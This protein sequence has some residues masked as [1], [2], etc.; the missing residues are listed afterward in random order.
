MAENGEGVVDAGSTAGQSLSDFVGS[1]ADDF[2]DMF[3][4]PQSD[5]SSEPTGDTPAA[6]TDGQSANPSADDPSSED[7]DSDDVADDDADA[8]DASDKEG[9]EGVA[10]EAPDPLANATALGYVVDGQSRNYD[11][12]RVIPGQGAIIKAADLPQ[13]QQRLSERDHLFETSRE[14]Y[15]TLNELEQRTAWKVRQPDGTEKTLTG[16]AGLVERDVVTGKALVALEELTDALR[17]P[18]KFAKLIGVDAQ[19]NIVPD[20]EQLEYLLTRSQLRETQVEQQI[21]ARFQSQASIQHTSAQDSEAATGQINVPDTFVDQY[22]AQLGVTG[23]APEDK[24]V[25]QAIAPRFIRVATQADVLQNPMLK[26][27]TPVIENAFADQVKHYASLRSTAAKTQATSAEATKAALSAQQENQARLAAAKTK[28][29]QK[30]KA[31]PRDEQG[32]FKSDERSDKLWEMMN[33]VGF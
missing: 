11:A 16:T 18:R 17:D 12:I 4:V 22:A 8:T 27:G 1:P 32:K 21:R 14:Q 2:D 13:L 33:G 15:R 5:T 7:E 6:P 19:G 30:V 25:L 23:L 10:A 28:P 26:V 29:T 24:A 3:S 31:Q 9:Q 20:A